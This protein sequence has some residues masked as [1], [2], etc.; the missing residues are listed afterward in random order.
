LTLFLVPMIY[1]TWIG[2][3]ERVKDRQA[4]REEMSPVGPPVPV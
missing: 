1:N 2:F 4:V 3:F